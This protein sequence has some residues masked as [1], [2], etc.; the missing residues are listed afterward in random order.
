MSL[1][2]EMLQVARLA[3][4]VLGEDASARIETFVRSQLHEGGGFADRDGGADLYYTVFGLDSLTALQIDLPDKTLEYLHS[5]GDGEGL[6]FVH[7]CCLARCLSNFPDQADRARPVLARIEKFRSAD[8]GY[9]QVEDAETGSAYACFLAYG[10]YS[11]HRLSVPEEDR[12][13]GCLSSLEQLSGGWAN[14]VE[15]PVANVPGS[16]AAIAVGRNLR[17]V[18]PDKAGEFLLSCFH[19]VSGGFV[20][21]PGAPLPDLLTTAVALHALD[22]LQIPIDQIKE[23]CLD[24]VDTLWTAD[25]GFHG[26]WEDDDLDLEYTYYGL[27][28]LGH[29][30]L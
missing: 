27:L 8:G 23:P 3:S 17:S 22:G 12:L 10:A 18:M 6:D 25:G 19:P 1:R 24:F 26:S 15:I 13:P 7:L 28:A 21:F 5:L 4:S 29:L 2:L 9:A 20:P 11:D 14:D 16:A 30:A